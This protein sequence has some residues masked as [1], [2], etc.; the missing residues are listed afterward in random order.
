M[1]STL[2]RWGLCR[3]GMGASLVAGLCLSACA[4]TAASA[5]VRSAAAADLQCDESA[6]AIVDNSPGRKRVEGC[7]RSLTYVR[8]CGSA[9]P[10]AGAWAGRCQWS[11]YPDEE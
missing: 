4:E 5:E 10:S 3:W 8:S 1:R 7:G 11:P 6:V 2:C 9:P